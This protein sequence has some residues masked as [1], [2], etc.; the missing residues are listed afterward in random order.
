MIPYHLEIPPDVASSLRRLSPDIKKSVK[1]AL[2]AL[3][4][5]PD[6]GDRL[7][8][9]LEGFWRYRVRRYRIV[10]MPARET[11]TILIYAIGH[12]RDIYE[13]R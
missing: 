5:E 3:A 8:G 7:T 13:R 10:Y 9:E 1:E 6:L 11:R 2:R 12:R 4:W